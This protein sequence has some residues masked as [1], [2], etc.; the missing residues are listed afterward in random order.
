MQKPKEI[1]N[2][3]LKNARRKCLIWSGN[4]IVLCTVSELVVQRSPE[5]TCSSCLSSSATATISSRSKLCGYQLE[6][7]E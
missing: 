1:T 5:G 7:N 4:G 3:S 6:R 2:P